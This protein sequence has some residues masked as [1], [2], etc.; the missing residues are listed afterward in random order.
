MEPRKAAVPLRV[1]PAT[2]KMMEKVR[3]RVVKAMTASGAHP[4]RVAGI[5]AF[6]MT[7]KLKIKLNMALI[8]THEPKMTRKTQNTVPRIQIQKER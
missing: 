7:I 5:T 8:P 1:N 3:I 2:R 4:A 6:Q